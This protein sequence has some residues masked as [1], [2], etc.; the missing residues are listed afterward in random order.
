MMKYRN[1]ILAVGGALTLQFFIGKMGS[2][3]SAPADFKGG[4]IPQFAQPFADLV[5]EK[6]ISILCEDPVWL[7]LCDRAG[8]YAL[9][10]KPAFADLLRAV[11]LSIAFSRTDVSKRARPRL[12]REYLHSIV[13]AVRE[14]RAVIEEGHPEV[15]NNFDEIA[16]DIQRTHDEY[17]LN[18]LLDSQL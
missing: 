2:A 9:I 16:A 17:A 13:E 7:E 14:M 8:E 18:A 11:A 12:Y 4:S 3:P 15:L 1:L 6:H 10:A 5:G